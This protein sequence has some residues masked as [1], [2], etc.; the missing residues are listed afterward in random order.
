M[1][2]RDNSSDIGGPGEWP[3]I[4]DPEVRRRL[5]GLARRHLGSF[6][7]LAEDVLMLSAIKWQRASPD[8][9]GV[10]RI[11]RVIASVAADLVRSELR[12]QG[13]TAKVAADPTLNGSANASVP[14]RAAELAALRVILA[15]VCRRLKRQPTSFDLEVIELLF[16]GHPVV[17]VARMIR[18]PRHAVRRSVRRWRT[19]L[20]AAGLGPLENI[21]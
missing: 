9:A 14:A 5:L 2:Q 19:I 12:A 8:K 4:D 10:A 18:V 3:R 6:G 11:E 20:A 13:R 15:D 1:A 17:E 21:A 16:A 7:Y